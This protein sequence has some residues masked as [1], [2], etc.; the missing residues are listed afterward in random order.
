MNIHLKQHEAVTKIM[1][2]SD[3]SSYADHMKENP[4][5]QCVSPCFK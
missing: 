4:P 2:G 3:D 5:V 1:M